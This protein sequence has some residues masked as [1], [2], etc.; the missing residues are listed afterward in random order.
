MKIWKALVTL[1]LLLLFTG[2]NAQRYFVTNQYVY[3]L[4]LMNP[5][6]AAYNRSCISV[7][8]FYQRQWFGMDNAPTT[9]LL[10]AQLPLGGN[11]GSG[12]YLY[13]DRNGNNRKLSL[14]QA[15]SVEVKLRENQRGNTSLVFG[16]AALLEQAS[17]DQSSFE[18]GVGIDPVIN[19][20][21]DGGFGF[22]ANTGM[23]LRIN[24]HHI[25]ASVTNIFPQNNPMYN[26]E[27]EPELPVDL[28]VH[29]GT[30]FKY[31]GRE[32][33]FEPLLYYR[34]NSLD[35]KRLDVNMKL[36]FP[37]YKD[38]FSFWGI[39]AYR[40]TLDHKWGKSLGAATTVGINYKGLNVGLEHQLG[41]T[42]AQG[43]YGSA[44]ML[45]FGY[46]FC[47]GQRIRS[48]PCSERDPMLQGDF[49]DGPR[50]RRKGLFRK[51]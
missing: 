23:M 45:V 5:S 40:H 34:Q 38:Q 15:F 3:D 39:L 25:G 17:I 6:A 18:G 32:I 21:S 1:S 7:N 37:T 14:M 47:S 24:R 33:Y 10:A 42:T 9:Q 44:V 51:R 8:G 50:S 22:N 12:T 27:W 49:G 43:H 30:W 31:P 41:L 4:F 20:N 11:I 28:H 2:I 19:G 13:N 35:D 16:L 46:N 29:A 26:S 36:D 48:L